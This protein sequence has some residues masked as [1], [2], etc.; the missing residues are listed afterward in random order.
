MLDAAE[1]DA[2]EVWVKLKLAVLNE[3]QFLLTLPNFF[4]TQVYPNYINLL[5]IICK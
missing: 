2:V 3:F 1:V 5:F 4:L